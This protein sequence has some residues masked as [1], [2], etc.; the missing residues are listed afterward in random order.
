ML[1]AQNH[2]RAALV[3]IVLLRRRRALQAQGIDVCPLYS[4]VWQRHC[5]PH[6]DSAYQSDQHGAGQGGGFQ[7]AKNAPAFS[8]GALKLPL[9]LAAGQACGSTSVSQEAQ[10]MAV[11]GRGGK[12][13][14]GAQLGGESGGAK[15]PPT[16][17][18]SAGVGVGEQRAVR[19][20]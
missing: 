16:R 7:M 20:P 15:G 11:F 12:G 10:I 9:T 17:G 3:F 6:Q 8:V 4:L 5:R 18:G 19:A 1:L 2:P 13:G 14:G